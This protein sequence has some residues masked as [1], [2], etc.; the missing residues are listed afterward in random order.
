M[1]LVVVTTCQEGG[2]LRD[3][4]ETPAFTV[5]VRNI[6][7]CLIGS[8]EANSGNTAIIMAEKDFSIKVID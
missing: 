7:D 6:D 5:V 2:L 3:D 8:F 1:E 4:L